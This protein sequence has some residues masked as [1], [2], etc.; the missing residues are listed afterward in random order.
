M[1]KVLICRTLDRRDDWQCGVSATRIGGAAGL[2]VLIL[3]RLV[4]VCTTSALLTAL[5]SGQLGSLPTGFIIA[6]V[7]GI[8]RPVAPR[9]GSAL[10]L[11]GGRP[12]VAP[13]FPCVYDP[14]EEP[15]K[16]TVKDYQEQSYRGRTAL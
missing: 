8:V 3:S 14:S 4:V 6:G 2:N 13:A 16:A 1:L 11:V 5:S 9:C 7:V 12:T 10:A 15:K